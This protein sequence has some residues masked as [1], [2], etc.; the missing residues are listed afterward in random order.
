MRMLLFKHH[1]AERLAM[2]DAA[3][4]ENFVVS[5]REFA[6]ACVD[7]ERDTI[8]CRHSDKRDKH[9]VISRFIAYTHACKQPGPVDG[10]LQS[11]G[12]VCRACGSFTGRLNDG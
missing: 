7:S 3:H 8:R 11:C 5:V 4:L 10:G 6:S 1:Q 9:T 2:A 12:C